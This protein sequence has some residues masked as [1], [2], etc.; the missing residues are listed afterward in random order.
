MK[1]FQTMPM[2]LLFL[3][4][5]KSLMSKTPIIVNRTVKVQNEIWK[6]LTGS[7]QLTQRAVNSI[8]VS[9]CMSM[10]FLGKGSNIGTAGWQSLHCVAFTRLSL[11]HFDS[12]DGG[13][14]PP[15]ENFEVIKQLKRVRVV[16][17][18]LVSH[19]LADDDVPSVQIDHYVKLFLSVCRRFWQKSHDELTGD[20]C[21][22]K[23]TTVDT[24][25]NQLGEGPIGALLGHP[26]EG[27]LAR[28][29]R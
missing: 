14:D 3:G 21:A 29:P 24:D 22:E 2:H 28:N 11:Y 18:C 16:W 17:F 25:D 8:S 5:E 19:L 27:R 6:G 4:L 9:W 13:L 10:A 15:A 26:R 23:T 12:L 20:E 1:K 7:M